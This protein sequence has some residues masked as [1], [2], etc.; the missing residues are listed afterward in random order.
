L[1]IIQALGLFGLGSVTPAVNGTLF[2]VASLFWY[3]GAIFTILFTTLL[4]WQISLI[5]P[6]YL[7]VFRNVV[8]ILVLLVA[9]ALALTVGWQ[10][11]AA[12]ILE[13]ILSTL[14]AVYALS[15]LHDCEFPMR[16]SC[17]FAYPA[18]IPPLPPG[19]EEHASLFI[20]EAD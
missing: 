20:K 1:L 9:L 7:R 12:G 6:A 18:S 13:I 19:M 4:N 2:Y 8:M 10:I 14:T 11:A 3:T 16:S 17:P 5:Q 15:Y